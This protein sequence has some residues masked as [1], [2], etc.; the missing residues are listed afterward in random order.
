MHD[1]SSVDLSPS[2]RAARAGAAS[3]ALDD[4]A[5]IV[6]EGVD[7][8]SFL[9]AQLSSDVGALAPGGVQYSSYNSPKGRVLANFSLWRDATRP[10]RFGIL[11]AADLASAIARRLSL[12]VLRAKVSVKD[13]SR[14]VALIGLVG[15][16]AHAAAMRAFGAAP[17]PGEAIIVAH[18]S[19]AI[20]L[21]DG[22]IVAI[23]SQDAREQAIRDVS[24]AAPA[25][26]ANAWRVAGIEAGVPLVTAATSEQFLPQAL[27]WEILG[28]VSFR[29]G[30]YPGQE[31][32]ARTQHLG[33][34]KER[35]YAFRS[36]VV[37]EPAARVFAPSFGEAPC[38]TVVNAAQDGDGDGA[39]L[40][41]V[42]QVAAHD[43]GELRLDSSSGPALSTVP[44]P[45]AIPE[46]RAP[47]GRIA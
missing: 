35:L 47:R 40:L 31:I 26:D 46:P 27:N 45:Y 43:A 9:Q 23:V 4:L 28:G 18:D 5:T 39:M 36:S 32:V 10:E 19:T 17:Q 44:L 41:A 7:A 21:P 6:V 11:L 33:R 22:R 3:I 13:V 12:F 15:A 2:F 29:K 14:D 1:M 34:L 20:G 8:A 37:P 38:G 42:V 30:C 25:A 24:P 16:N